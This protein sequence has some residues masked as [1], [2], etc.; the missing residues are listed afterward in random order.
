MG[1]SKGYL[2]PTTPE[3]R[4]AKT[5]LT[6]YIK[7]G[8]NNGDRTKVVGDYAKAHKSS[9]SF[10]NVGSVANKLVGL[11][12]LIQSEGLENAL[13]Q[14]GLSHLIDADS[15][16]L[17][18]ELINY[19]NE[20]TITIEDSIIR[21]SLSQTFRDLDLQDVDQLGSLDAKDILITFFIKYIQNNFQNSFFEKIQAVKSVSETNTIIDNIDEYIDFTI[22]NNQNFEVLQKLDWH[23]E[24]GK[25][26]ISDYC[27][28]CY[29][30]LIAM[31]EV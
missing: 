8:S 10:L 29:D 7:S 16:T 12:N 4:K 26:F 2:P 13:T 23:G 18:N 31:G 11:L 6:T 25:E 5:T 24:E 27:N 15:S 1:T 22:R 30:L 14:V 3:W 19:F 21:D 28:N 20:A 17:Y 9:S